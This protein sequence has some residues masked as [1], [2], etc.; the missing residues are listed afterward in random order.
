MFH[1]EIS[2]F[3]VRC[4]VGVLLLGIIRHPFEGDAITFVFFPGVQLATGKK[5]RFLYVFDRAGSQP[6]PARLPAIALV[7]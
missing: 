5:S 6:A 7:V 2:V 3:P 1:T 4:H